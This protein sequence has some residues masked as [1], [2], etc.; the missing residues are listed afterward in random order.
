MWSDQGAPRFFKRLPAACSAHGPPV[1][2]WRSVGLAGAESVEA[3]DF[4]S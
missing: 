2:R 3:V 1:E 4:V